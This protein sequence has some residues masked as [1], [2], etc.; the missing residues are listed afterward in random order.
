MLP[1]EVKSFYFENDL[2]RVVLIPDG[3]TTPALVSMSLITETTAAP[4]AFEGTPIDVRLDCYTYNP[5]LVYDAVN[6]VT[7]VCM[8]AGFGNTTT[9]VNVVQTSGS[10]TGRVVEGLLTFNN[11]APAGQKYFIALDGNLTTECFAIGCKYTSMALM[12]AIYVVS[13]EQKDTLNLPIVQRLLLD[14]YNSGPFQVRVNAVGRDE[15][16]LRLPQVFAGQY[17]AG[18][19]PVIRNA[20][21]IVPVMAAGDQVDITI[22]CPDPFPT[23]ITGVTWTGQYNNRGIRRV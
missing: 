13:N 2:L 21:N 4:L 17:E 20:Q 10:N 23:A 3:Q 8:P 1:G 15:F 6:D 5:T 11:A 18:D 7:K 16:L 12:P 9:K 14:S 19:L 22:E